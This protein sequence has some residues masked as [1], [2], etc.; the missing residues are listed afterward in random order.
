MTKPFTVCMLLYGHYTREADRLLC[1]L[2]RPAWL[3]SFDLR[4]GLNDVNDDT[5]EVVRWLR[6]ESRAPGV[7]IHQ[8][9]GE[10]PY[11]KYPLMRRMFWEEDP[12]QTP[13]TMWFDDD[14]WV[15]DDAPAHWFDMVETVIQQAAMIGDVWEMGYTGNEREFIEDQPWY[16]NRPH[17]SRFR[18]CT[19]GWWTIRTDILQQHNWPPPE[20][21][22][23][24][25]DTM[26]GALCHQQQYAVKH[27]DKHVCINADEKGR[28]SRGPRRGASGKTSRYGANY[29]RPTIP[30]GGPQPASSWMDV[31]DGKA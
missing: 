22:H 10:P 21:Q 20:L 17:Q 26:L 18:F 24:G 28:R 23:D 29:V 3:P 11:H 7:S 16:R 1:S 31:L 30:A 8:F 13:Y 2:M 27:F 14:S 4:I 5:V 25:G 12:I 6:A 19:G 9:V 15:K